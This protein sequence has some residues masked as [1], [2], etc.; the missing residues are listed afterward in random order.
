ML[1]RLQKGKVDILLYAKIKE[2]VYVHARSSC[3]GDEDV[4]RMKKKNEKKDDICNILL[5]LKFLVQCVTST[6][7]RVVL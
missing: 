5:C 1:E 7:G 2:E 3:L 4:D 6:L